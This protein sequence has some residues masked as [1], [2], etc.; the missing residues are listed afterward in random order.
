MRS[1][2]SSRRA[3]PAPLG[4]VCADQGRRHIIRSVSSGTI[5]IR[6]N[7]TA[8]AR[9][10]ANANATTS[11]P[12]RWAGHRL[13]PFN[14]LQV[15]V[16]RLGCV[17]AGSARAP[18][19][20]YPVERSQRQVRCPRLVSTR[21][22]ARN[23]EQRCARMVDVPVNRSNSPRP[24]PYFGSMPPRRRTSK[25][26]PGKLAGRMKRRW[27]VVLLRAKGERVEAPRC[28]GGQGGRKNSV[29]SGRGPPPADH[30]AGVGVSPAVGGRPT[31]R[32]LQA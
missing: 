27:R 9:T 25:D 10:T 4:S 5:W 6:R 23:M 26:T 13:G 15:A 8:A 32:I 11:R 18:A 22:F 16:G 31:R 1:A 17:C 21:Q 24:H 14:L 20:P 12:C 7:K 19:G 2:S 30:G 28:A 3:Q 29:R